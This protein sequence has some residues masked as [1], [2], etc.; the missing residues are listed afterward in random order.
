MNTLIYAEFIAKAYMCQ[1][2]SQLRECYIID[3]CNVVEITVKSD[4]D[5]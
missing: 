5:R 2:A 1:N 3:S 4:V